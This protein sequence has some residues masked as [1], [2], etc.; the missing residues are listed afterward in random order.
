[1]SEPSS[2]YVPITRCNYTITLPY[3]SCIAYIVYCHR[4]NTKQPIF[5]T[6]ISLI[7]IYYAYYANIHKIH[8]KYK[9][10]FGA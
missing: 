9:S 8:N 2:F 6:H 1:M 10:Y 7:Y 5:A 4:I 3:I